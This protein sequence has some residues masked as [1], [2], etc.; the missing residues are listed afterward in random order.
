MLK[1]PPTMIGSDCAAAEMRAANCLICPN[2]FRFAA[3]CSG[4]QPNWAW[5]AMT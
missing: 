5:V 4:C 3:L 1:S 2:C